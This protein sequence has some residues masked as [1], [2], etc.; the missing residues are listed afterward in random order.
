MQDVENMTHDEIVKL[1]ISTADQY[2]TEFL[3]NTNNIS[4]RY[5]FYGFDTWYI[6]YYAFTKDYK[7]K[8]E[9]NAERIFEKYAKILI[10]YAEALRDKE[11]RL[12]CELKSTIMRLSK[13]GRGLY[14]EYF[15]YSFPDVH[16]E[17]QRGGR[18]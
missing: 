8:D 2:M 14:V 11:P 13:I 1:F 4:C 5:H 17:V 12:R 7:R 9:R 18:L 10:N 3:E 15:P 6:D 16:E